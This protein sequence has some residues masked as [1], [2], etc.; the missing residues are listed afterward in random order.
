MTELRRKLFQDIGTSGA[1]LVPAG[2]ITVSKVDTS[3]KQNGQCFNYGQ[4][5]HYSA[6]CPKSGKSQK[7]GNG[8]NKKSGNFN[9]QSSHGSQSYNQGG[10][11]QQSYN[12]SG[13]GY[14]QQSHN[15][16]DGGNHHQT[17]ILAVAH[18]Q[19]DVAHR[20]IMTQNGEFNN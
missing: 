7:S 1:Q 8:G 12:Q 5:G 15:Q 20:L 16:G 3:G 17:I 18:N 14:S 4:F 19:A 2:G 10:G 13:G 11:N 6:K 9:N